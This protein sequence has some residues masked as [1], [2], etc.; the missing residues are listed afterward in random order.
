M[1][2]KVSTS[3]N[4]VPRAPQAASWVTSGTDEN[5][6]GPQ[7]LGLNINDQSTKSAIDT[8]NQSFKKVGISPTTDNTVVQKNI[9]STSINKFSGQSKQYTGGTSNQSV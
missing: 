2:I 3:N 7:S 8:N 6:L 1:G 5:S 4:S 9:G